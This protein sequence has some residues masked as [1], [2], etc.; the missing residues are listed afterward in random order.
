MEE[1]DYETWLL[2]IF[3]T[4]LN[5][6]LSFDAEDMENILS[7][8]KDSALKIMI[9]RLLG[10][11][12]IEQLQEDLKYYLR[13][14]GA[15]KQ[16]SEVQ[17][18]VLDSQKSLDQ[19]S[20]QIDTLNLHREDLLI[21]RVNFVADLEKTENE[22]SSIGGDYASKRSIFKQRIIDLSKDIDSLSQ[23]IQQLASR[24]LP[25]IFAPK[26]LSSLTKTIDLELE[27]K[28]KDIASKYI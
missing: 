5:E 12:L 22:L 28:R 3:P 13:T 7:P 17:E 15:G 19:L 23:E 2:D 24:L 1:E 20:T 6:I 8:R 16:Y 21:Q 25:F 26:L 27:R 9:K 4:G 11:H 10:L 14:N 18:K